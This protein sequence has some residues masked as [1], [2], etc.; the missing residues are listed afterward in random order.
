MRLELAAD[1]A[2]RGRPGAVA[3]EAVGGSRDDDRVGRQP[4]VV[5]RAEADHL[6][7][8]LDLDHR[9]LRRAQHG[10]RLARPRLVHRV[11]LGRELGVEASSAGRGKRGFDRLAD[12]VVAHSS[13][14]AGGIT[15]EGWM[16]IEVLEESARTPRRTIS[17][18]TAC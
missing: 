1:E 15:S 3:S 10:D 6:A 8:A 13:S 11:E 14:A 16:L 18:A 5:V 17:A 7:P 4:Q 12:D 2:D 9:A